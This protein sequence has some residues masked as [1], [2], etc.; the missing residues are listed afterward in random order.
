MKEKINSKMVLSRADIRSGVM[1]SLALAMFAVLSFV[2]MSGKMYGT[3]SLLISAFILINFVVW[4]QNRKKGTNP[5]KAFEGRDWWSLSVLAWLLICLFFPLFPG[6]LKS[7][8]VQQ[9]KKAFVEAMLTKVEDE[10]FQGLTF[11]NIFF[12][13]EKLRLKG[14]TDVYSLKGA[15]FP[16]EWD[17]FK[18]ES[19]FSSSKG[20]APAIQWIDILEIKSKGKRELSYSQAQSVEKVDFWIKLNNDFLDRQPKGLVVAKGFAEIKA[21]YPKGI[22]RDKFKLVTNVIKTNNITFAIV[23]GEYIQ[24]LFELRNME[25]IEGKNGLFSII[26][27]VES[28]LL[29]FLGLIWLVLIDSDETISG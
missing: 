20:P 11:N 28:F 19:F 26:L 17:R 7:L 15:A 9:K 22:G 13:G 3:W 12:A 23:G 5:K 16:L 4:V 29:Y 21:E 6:K 14:Y 24:K 1:H 8:I 18:V 2:K 10:T 25:R 27:F